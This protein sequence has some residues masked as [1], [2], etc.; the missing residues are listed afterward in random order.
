MESDAIAGGPSHATQGDRHAVHVGRSGPDQ[1]GALGHGAHPMVAARARVGMS[2]A[3][4][5][6]CVGSSQPVVARWECG[7]LQPTGDQLLAIAL[8]LS[9]PAQEIARG[10]GCG[11]RRRSRR[12]RDRRAAELLGGRL[13]LLREERGLDRYAAARL[14][15]ISPRRL[16][17][18][19]AGRDASVG[20]LLVLSI[21]LELSLDDLLASVTNDC[22]DKAQV[23]PMVSS[24]RTTRAEPDR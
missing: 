7:S 19:E 9:V 20:E 10:W 2:Q 4:L 17:Q 13:R 15:R 3:E 21:V 16:H 6:R 23:P 5:A 12:G 14:S 1:P 8:A 11:Q 18:I 24:G 22:L